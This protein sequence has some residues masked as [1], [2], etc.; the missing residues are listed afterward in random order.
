MGGLAIVKLLLDTH[1][2]IWSLRDP[3]RLSRRVAAALG[4]AA[5][6]KWLS[7]ISIWE[8]LL[9]AER[10]RLVLEPDPPAWIRQQIA[11]LPFR[12]APITHEVA[13]ESRTVDLRHD[14][15]A[16]RFLMATARVYDL[17]LVTADRRLLG[18]KSCAVLANR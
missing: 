15:P 18:T 17:T 13:I 4:E 11:G 7:P 9:L 10:G 5:N 3:A 6:E 1:I 16:D 12:Q 8:T 2:F 14:D